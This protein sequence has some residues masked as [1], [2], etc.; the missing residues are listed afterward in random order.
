LENE[1][2]SIKDGAVQMTHLPRLSGK[3]YLLYGVSLMILKYLVDTLLST[4][5]FHQPWSIGEYFMPGTFPD[6][7]L[8]TAPT[9]GVTTT[10]YGGMLL[11]S[12]PFAFIGS[13]LTLRRLKVIGLPPWLVIFFYVPFINMVF[14]TILA[15]VEHGPTNEKD[16]LII[17]A[18]EAGISSQIISLKT[19]EKQ[20]SPLS[21]DTSQKTT[22]ATARAQ[23]FDAFP[24]PAAEKIS[25]EAVQPPSAPEAPAAAA[26]DSHLLV[27][28]SEASSTTSPDL[29]LVMKSETA[30]TKAFDEAKTVEP[31]IPPTL[32]PEIS[33]AGL[34]VVPTDGTGKV[35]SLGEWKPRPAPDI[36]RHSQTV[37]LKPISDPHEKFL[38][39]MDKLPQ[40]GW[41]AL[42]AA[43]ALPVPIAVIAALFSVSILG[44]YG[45]TV[46]TAIPFIA[47]IAAAILYGWRK[48]RTILECM[49]VSII[50]LLIMA[51]ILLLI[52]FEG[53][54]CLLMAAP[55]AVGIGVVGGAVGYL[56][57]V[58]LPRSESMTRLMGCF[59]IIL[60]LLIAGEYLTPTEV[61]E[62]KN[63]DT[64]EIAAPPAVVW[65]Y[66]ID[67][68]PIGPPTDW[69]FKTGIAY[70]MRARI[71]GRGVGAIRH[72]IFTTGEFVEP[73]NVWVAPHQLRFGVLAQAPPMHELSLYP[74]L[75]PPHLDNYLVA[76]QGQ[77]LL[78][79]TPG[80]KTKLEGAT[81][82]QNYMGPSPYWRIWSDWI[83][84][85]IHL[86][87]MNHVKA[88]AENEVARSHP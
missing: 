60:P 65:K 54:I 71:E 45:W 78:T 52:P 32:V 1:P 85:R 37:V 41:K 3:R 51:C 86:R 34:V 63:V 53:V 35:A 11:A 73:I 4:Y 6:N 49:K 29:D 55:L 77:F 28:K 30:P 59:A 24:T 80:G 48:E 12:L 44:T 70:P 38:A 46:F 15:V 27:P 82:Y 8:F 40:D 66:L 10:F 16:E 76:R 20:V 5:V 22:E 21:T 61:P 74:D 75:H 57:Q 83:I 18:L 19:H 79:D 14:F 33:P 7:S 13:V 87:V 67:F 39:L 26:F 50:S 17:P 58:N 31:E 56:I 42:F 68:P 62:Y 88:L 81:W 9:A 84:H 47:S 23:A 2:V 36:R 69:V 25:G 43:A 64:I 72:C